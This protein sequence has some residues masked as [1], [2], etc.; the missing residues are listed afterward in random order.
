MVNQ[1]R[2]NTRYNE[3]NEFHEEATNIYYESSAGD[4]DVADHGDDK[5]EKGGHEGGKLWR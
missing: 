2:G 4:R 1:T 3:Y 5:A